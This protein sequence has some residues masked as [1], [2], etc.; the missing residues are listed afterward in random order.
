MKLD[1]L[2]SLKEHP[3]EWLS[4]EA[5]SQL[6]GVSRTAVWKQI[7]QLRKEGY[8]IESVPSKGYRMAA[9][10]ETLSREGIL[11]ELR[12]TAL[13]HDVV[14]LKT[15]DSTNR[16]ARQIEGDGVLVISEEQT[17]GRGRL[18]RHWTS[19]AG[20][21]LWFSLVL[22]PELDPMQA[23]AV[24]QIAASAVWQ[25]IMEVTGIEAEIKWPNDILIGGRKVCG[26]LTEMNAELGA[27]ERLVVGIGIN[28]NL[29]TLPEELRETATSL[30]LETG[31]PWSRK[32]ILSAVIRAFETDFRAYVADGLL[33]S[34]IARCREHSSLI[35]KPIRILTGSREEYGEAL[36]L[37]DTGELLVR[38]EDGTVA[39]LISGEISVRPRP[40][41]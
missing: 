41:D 28:V 8:A 5:L 35:G 37:T 12:D 20:E 2:R 4:G 38:R 39:P 15:V 9:G 34:V 30:L 6:A 40:Q 21:G 31:R 27:I 7:N 16:Y 14:S 25:G 17:G 19:P 13:I 32:A 29:P 18:G 3:G 10:D 36:D 1:I 24:T 11:L 23:A 26:I 22:R 33:N